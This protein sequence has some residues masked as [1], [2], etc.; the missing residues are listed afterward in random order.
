MTFKEEQ[1]QVFKVDK[2]EFAQVI[3]L[4][5]DPRKNEV[6]NK[7]PW[8]TWLQNPQQNICKPYSTIYLKDHLA[9]STWLPFRDVGMLWYTGINMHNTHKWKKPLALGDFPRYRLFNYDSCLF[10]WYQLNTSQ[11]QPQFL[12]TTMTNQMSLLWYPFINISSIAKVLSR[13]KLKV[14]LYNYQ[15]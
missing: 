4:D 5:K 7:P 14:L 2:M 12:Q 9:R 13:W 10:L 8:W 6:N 1:Q 11:I 3:T 15:L